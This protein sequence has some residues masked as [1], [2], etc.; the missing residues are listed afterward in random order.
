MDAADTRLKG[1]VI[2][3]VQHPSGLAS[4]EARD[5][6]YLYRL[7]SSPRP[8]G[9]WAPT[10]EVGL[11]TSCTIQ[12]HHSMPVQHHNDLRIQGRNCARVWLL[13]IR[14]CLF[15]RSGPIQTIQYVAAS[16]CNGRPVLLITPAVD[17]LRPVWS[18]TTL[19]I[20]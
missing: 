10:Y 19:S 12:I 15:R 14:E 16:P 8:R 13:T 4:E 7:G 17:R 2:R 6:L 3:E 11:N 20:S 9:V 5:E 18:P 1:T